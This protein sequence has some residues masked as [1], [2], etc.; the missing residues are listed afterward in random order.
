M[1]FLPSEP[2]SEFEVGFGE[3]IV[4]RDCGRAELEPDEQMTFT[5]EDGAEYDV[6]R[7]D[8]GFYATPSLNARLVEHGLHAVLVKNRIGRYFVLLVEQGKEELFERYLAVEGLT[9]V[10]R[11]DSTEA[12]EALE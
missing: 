8:W 9:V 7:K 10:R 2:P 5:T 11:L 4:M 1:R 6:A 12:L 3:R